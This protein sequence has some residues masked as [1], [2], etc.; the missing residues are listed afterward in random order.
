V[1]AK[2]EE[3]WWPGFRNRKGESL[4]IIDEFVKTPSWIK[5][6]IATLTA[7]YRE[8]KLSLRR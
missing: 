8:R 4:E 1:K 5:G 2:D 6:R 3:T 7:Q